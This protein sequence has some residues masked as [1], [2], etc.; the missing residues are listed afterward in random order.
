MY[1]FCNEGLWFRPQK[2]FETRERR[3]DKHTRTDTCTHHFYKEKVMAKNWFND[4]QKKILKLARFNAFQSISPA[5]LSFIF[6]YKYNSVCI[7][8]TYLADMSPST[9][10]PFSLLFHRNQM[11]YSSFIGVARAG[12]QKHIQTIR[13]SCIYRQAKRRKKIIIIDNEFNLNAYVH[14]PET[15]LINRRKK[16]TFTFTI[17]SRNKSL[18]KHNDSTMK[19]T[20]GKTQ[21][22]RVVYFVICVEKIELQLNWAKTNLNYDYE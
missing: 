8:F 13:F 19:N 12:Q 15:I 21:F 16:K 5:C 4:R 22:Q 2:S 11:K 7:P 6:S 9:F 3:T 1:D 18:Q 10:M 14:Q 20:V 17:C